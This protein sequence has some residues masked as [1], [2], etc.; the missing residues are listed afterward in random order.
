M[1]RTTATVADVSSVSSTHQ[2]RATLRQGFI[3]VKLPRTGATADSNPR[4]RVTSSEVV[5]ELTFA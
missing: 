5:Y 1:I 2:I 4:S 3:D